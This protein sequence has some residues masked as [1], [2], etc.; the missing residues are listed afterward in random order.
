MLSETVSASTEILS[1]VLSGLRLSVVIPTYNRKASLL[2]AL[3]ALAR[4]TYPASQFEVVVVSDGATD[5][6]AEAVR[7][8]KTPYRLR[9][10]EQK[11]SGPSAAR[12]YGVRLACAPTIVYLDDDIEP[13]AEFLEKHAEAQEREEN[14]VLIGPQSEPPGEAIPNFIAWEHAMLQKQY[15]RFGSGEWEAGPNNLYSGNF[16]V[17]REALIAV[18]GFNEK[19]TRQEDVELGFR[20]EQHGLHFRFEG[21]ANGFHRPTRTF[22]SWLRTPFEYG[23]RDVQMARDGGEERAM[24]L[25]RRH[26]RERNRVTRFLAKRCIGVPL[27]EKGVLG[28]CRIGAQHLPRKF[29]LG[30]CSLLFNLRYL[31]GMSR[32]LGGRQKLW[33]A[34]QS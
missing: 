4:Q 8:L 12:N 15:D 5:G 31:Q 11:N 2:R 20:L 27:L 7:A 25:A 17:K 23:R 32:E 33:R 3:N 21:K 34:I 30:F 18:G 24:E 29:A 16:S 22:E 6:S 13:V 10:V 9:F 19:F 28:F 26:F 14:L 1:T